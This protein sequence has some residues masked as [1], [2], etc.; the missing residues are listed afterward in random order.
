MLLTEL[1][2][3]AAA[4]LVSAALLLPSAVRMSPAGA[5]SPRT[6]FALLVILFLTTWAGGIWLLPVG[7]RVWGAYWLGFLVI[8]LLVG[9]IIAVARA[10]HVPAA[11]PKAIP[12]SAAERQLSIVSVLALLLILFLLLAIVIGYAR[13]TTP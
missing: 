1:V 2:L 7:P 5:N 13:R 3:A 4:S 11:N 12:G 6:L 8:A 9:L 10:P